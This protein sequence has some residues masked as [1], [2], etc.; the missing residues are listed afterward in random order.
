MLSTKPAFALPQ[1][2]HPLC[3][4]QDDDECGADGGLHEGVAGGPAE[5]GVDEAGE[6][7]AHD[8]A[9]VEAREVEAVD[10]GAVGVCA[11]CGELVDEAGAHGVHE[12]LSEGHAPDAGEDDGQRGYGHADGAEQVDEGAEDEGAG[13]GFAEPFEG[14]D[15]EG[16]S[17]ADGVAGVHH[18]G[19]G[20]GVAVT[21]F[22]HA[23]REHVAHGGEG[24]ERAGIN[25]QQAADAGGA[26]N[27]EVVAH[28]WAVCGAF[29]HFDFGQVQDKW[30]RHEKW[31][32]KE[33]EGC[34]PADD[35][36]A[37]AAADAPAKR[38]DEVDGD[39]TG[40]RAA[41]VKMAEKGGYGGHDRREDD[42][43]Q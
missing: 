25:E 18:A 41:Q 19:E 16:G 32:A 34:F 40:E 15:E 26:R 14:V 20:V 12:E 29:G 1:R 9:K 42:G 11:V 27:G 3:Q 22:G 36:G 33:D 8:A 21:E 17:D 31:Q 28:F 43:H 10:K 35:V 6:P 23:Q 13:A 4:P 7:G 2:G 5:V 24:K 30:Q 37:D 39:I 38:A